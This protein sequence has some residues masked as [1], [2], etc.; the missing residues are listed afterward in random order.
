MDNLTMYRLKLTEKDLDLRYWQELV[1]A[2]LRCEIN[3]DEQEYSDPDE[4]TAFREG[5]NAQ[6]VL[7]SEI[8]EQWGLKFLPRL[9]GLDDDDAK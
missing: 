9:A 5:V 8:I 3:I 6:A 4:Q 1:R 2:I 7:A